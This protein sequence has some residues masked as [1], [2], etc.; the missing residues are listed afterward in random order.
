VEPRPRARRYVDA[1]Q[2]AL[3]APVGRPR[4]ARA[5]ARARAQVTGVLDRKETLLAALHRMNDEVEAG[6]HI[7]P[8]TGRHCA[9]FQASYARVV[10]ELKKARTA[11]C[12]AARRAFLLARAPAQRARAR[13]V[14]R[15]R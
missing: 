8:A 6:L 7:D 13:A 14:A 10:L 12:C 4:G 11:R 9:G 5:G 1:G 3:G 15:Q 2:V